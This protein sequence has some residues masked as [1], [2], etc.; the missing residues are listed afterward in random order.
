MK[1]Y[2]LF[3]I[4]LGMLFAACKS[5]PEKNIIPNW[6]TDLLG[7]LVK[8]T[9]TGEEVMQLRNLQL[10]SF[11][12]IHDYGYGNSEQPDTIPEIPLPSFSKTEILNTHI[13]SMELER[14]NL[15]FR[16]SNTLDIDIKK[17][18]TIKISQN[19]NIILV[20]TLK[21]DLKE[22]A[23]V[24][25]SKKADLSGK[26]LLPEFTVNVENLA[27]HGTRGV[28]LVPG[29][30]KLVTNFFFE[31]IIFKTLSLKPGSYTFSD[32]SAFNLNGRVVKTAALQG[33]IISYV[34]NNF[35]FTIDMQY[36]FLNAVYTPIDSLF[37][38]NITIVPSNI[39]N[40][41]SAFKQNISNE[42]VSSITQ[43][44]FVNSRVSFY[45]DQNITITKDNFLDLQLVGD[46]Q[47]S[48]NK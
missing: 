43:A 23:G 25:I 48:V 27:T 7:P 24:F 42:K 39:S 44:M 19:G 33:D 21:E 36:Y 5:N 16:F 10:F 40:P 15:Y 1:T 18:A 35:P 13:E 14:G 47:I 4:A 6:H 17:G 38:K 32:T 45:S 8:S 46:L 34:K 41:E 26:T 9:V 29:D 12:T 11:S 28:P 37:D 22:K 3:I 30:K 2:K 31:E 20:D